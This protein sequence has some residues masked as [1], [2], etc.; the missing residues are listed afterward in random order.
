MA[1]DKRRA[2][3]RLIETSVEFYVDADKL[4]STSVNLSASGVRLN[5]DRPL[6]ICLRMPVEG[7]L[8]EKRA[9]LVWSRK[10]PGG[11][12]TY[13]FEFIEDGC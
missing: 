2:A 10:E 9:R 6:E 12:M 4:R 13:G 1:K 5:T 11:G 7:E 3:R 8:L